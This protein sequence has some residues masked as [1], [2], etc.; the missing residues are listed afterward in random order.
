MFPAQPALSSSPRPTWAQTDD[1]GLVRMLAIW[2]SSWDKPL[3]NRIDRERLWFGTREVFLGMSKAWEMR[4]AGSASR[5]SP[6]AEQSFPSLVL[7]MEQ[8]QEGGKGL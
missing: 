1:V 6:P 2:F 8:R 4:K 5:T 3:Q 7:L